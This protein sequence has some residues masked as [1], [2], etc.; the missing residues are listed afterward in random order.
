MRALATAVGIKAPALYNHFPDKE[1]LY[2]AAMEEAFGGHS[3]QL[4]GVLAQP[5]PPWQR[6]HQFVDALVHLMDENPR[7]L[8]LMQRELLDGDEARLQIL[9]TRV[10]GDSFQGFVAL[11]QPLFPTEQA[12]LLAV[13]IT[14][15]IKE[16]YVMAPLLRHLPGCDDI[17]VTP[18]LITQQ[19][20]TLLETLPPRENR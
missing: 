9:A 4:L 6:L 19:V 2:V 18:A 16:H 20:M 17:T 15:M 13:T 12:A 8:R 1:A 3:A 5:I 11:L 7:L 14:G 10:F